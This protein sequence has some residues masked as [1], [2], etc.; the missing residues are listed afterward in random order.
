MRR[1]EIGSERRH[2]QQILCHDGEAS[3]GYK[4]RFQIKV[5]TSVV[6]ELVGLSAK[7]CDHAGKV[8]GQLSS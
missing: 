8:L 6:V 7:S 5:V 2:G 3:G 1:G 4:D